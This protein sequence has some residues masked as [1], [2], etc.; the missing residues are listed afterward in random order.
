MSSRSCVE[1]GGNES[2]TYILNSTFAFE[3][4]EEGTYTLCAVYEPFILSQLTA[5]TVEALHSLE[6]RTTRQVVIVSADT[7]VQ[8]FAQAII[9]DG[10]MRVILEF[11]GVDDLDLNAHFQVDDGSGKVRECIILLVVVL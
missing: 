9:P 3:E 5:S 10:A 11:S 2:Q 6:F 7:E 1:R 8:L 4:V